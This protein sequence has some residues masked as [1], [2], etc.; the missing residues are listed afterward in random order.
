MGD[1]SCN[2]LINVFYVSLIC[3]SLCHATYQ[4]RKKLQREGL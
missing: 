1:I 2:V 3:I 4:Y